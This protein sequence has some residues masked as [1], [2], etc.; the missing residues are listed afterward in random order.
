MLMNKLK[1]TSGALLSVIAVLFGMSSCAETA[2]DR[3]T[4]IQLAVEGR[5]EEYYNERLNNCLREYKVKAETTVDSI[6][7][8]RSKTEKIDTISPPLRHN[9]PGKPLIH[10][11]EFE[12]PKPLPIDEDSLK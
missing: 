5:V 6:L 9:R 1:L 12:E 4:R 3:D 2:P 7:R 11:K 10:F 8:I